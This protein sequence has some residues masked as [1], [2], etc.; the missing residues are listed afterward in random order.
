IPNIS[1]QRGT[2]TVV[3]VD[4]LMGNAVSGQAKFGH[5]VNL[6]AIEEVKVLH[7]S[8]GAEYGNQGGAM[9]QIITKN[10]R[11]NY[12]GGA[13]Y[14]VRNDA[15]NANLFLNNANPN[16]I[17]RQKYRNNFWELNIGGPIKIPKLFPNHKKKKLFF[18]SSM[19][20]Q[21]TT[22]PADFASVT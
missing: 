21:K 17:P 19:K 12:S 14:Y 4:G 8:Y 13:Y 1:G 11:Q 6:D 15:S 16:Y 3:S 9:V 10:G 22:T 7:N 2:S 18:L 5:T 20:N